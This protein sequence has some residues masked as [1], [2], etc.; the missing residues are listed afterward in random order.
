MYPE[1]HQLSAISAQTRPLCLKT[2]N[3]GAFGKYFWDRTVCSEKHWTFCSYRLTSH[4]TV[5]SP[6]PMPLMTEKG[7]C[8]APNTSMRDTVRARTAAS[9]SDIRP[10]RVRGRPQSF[11]ILSMGERPFSD[12][13]RPSKNSEHWLIDFQR[14]KSLRRASACTAAHF[15]P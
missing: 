11:P 6:S 15:I 5:H 7:H 3:V 8:R 1:A 10:R 12:V 2:D 13:L 4:S 14:S 9:R